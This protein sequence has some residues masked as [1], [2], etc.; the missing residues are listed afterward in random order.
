MDERTDAINRALPE[1]QETLLGQALEHARVAAIVLDEEG[2]FL[3]ANEQASVMT[4]YPRE[5]LLQLGSRGLAVDDG[6]G[7]R[8]EGM[9]RGV[10]TRGSGP[11]R[12]RDGSIKRV[13]YRVESTRVSGLPYYVGVFWED[14]G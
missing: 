1:L 5:E 9:A 8:L 12:C 3:A 7:E 10:L 4:G 6:I 13:A 11:I 14:E 2:R